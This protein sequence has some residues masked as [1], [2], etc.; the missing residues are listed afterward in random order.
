M[1]VDGEF[2]RVIARVVAEVEVGFVD[3]IGEWFVLKNVFVLK[4]NDF[5]VDVFMIG[6]LVLVVVD[7]DYLRLLLRLDFYGVREKIIIGDGNC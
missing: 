4:L 5:V 7:V 1:D 6:L 3:V 2:D